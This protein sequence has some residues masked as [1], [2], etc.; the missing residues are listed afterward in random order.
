[1]GR[2]DPLEEEMATCSSIPA[3]KIPCTEKPGGVQSM[4]LQR[5]RPDWTT[6]DEHQSRSVSR[7]WKRP[8][9]HGG[10]ACPLPW[11]FRCFHLP[12]SPGMGLASSQML[13]WFLPLVLHTHCSSL[14]WCSPIPL[15]GLPLFIQI[16]SETLH[17]WR[18][19]PLASKFKKFPVTLSRR[20]FL[21]SPSPSKLFST[22][23][24]P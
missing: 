1:M 21:H 12:Q 10:A 20:L 6:E 16:P 15:L 2:E 4:G 5:F 23:L 22:T 3:S 17:P 13:S 14:E 8:N 24:L 11:L 7:L 18:G 9:T 19:L